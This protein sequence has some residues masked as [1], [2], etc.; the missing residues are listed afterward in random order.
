MWQDIISILPQG[1]II[2]RRHSISAYRSQH[3]EV[4]EA[5]R[6]AK[7]TQTSLTLTPSS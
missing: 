5:G 2:W 6:G 3:E 7:R 4:P 1:H